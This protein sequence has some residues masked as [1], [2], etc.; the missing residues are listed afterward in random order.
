MKDL[1]PAIPDRENAKE[2]HSEFL[3]LHNLTFEIKAL[4]MNKVTEMTWI[5]C[6]NLIGKL[7]EM[8]L[9]GYSDRE[10]RDESIFNIRLEI[11]KDRSKNFL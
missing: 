1:V 9:Q 11:I 10:Q 3:E 8:L 4:K 7:N 5:K 2:K 6:Q